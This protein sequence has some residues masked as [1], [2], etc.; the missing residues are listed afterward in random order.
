[1]KFIFYSEHGE[2]ADLASYL[3]HVEGH[4]V[5]LHIPDHDHKRIAEGIVPHVDDWY[6]YIGQGYVWCFDSCKFGDLQDWLR[7]QG[8][9]VVGGSRLGDELEN[10]RQKGQEW[11]EAVGFDQP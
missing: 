5:V 6:R 7:E 11:F 4:E 10:D 8:E 2:L 3:I 1:M 9:A